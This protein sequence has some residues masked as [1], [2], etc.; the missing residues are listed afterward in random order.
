MSTLTRMIS[1]KESQGV[2]KA[3]GIIKDEEKQS[4]TVD[5]FKNIS[6]LWVWF[7]VF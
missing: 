6:K 2:G 1:V 3:K 4:G 5:F 7:I